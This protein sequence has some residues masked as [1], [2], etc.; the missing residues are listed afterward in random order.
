MAVA[1]RTLTTAPFSMCQGVWFQVVILCHP[2]RGHDAERISR[3]PRTR[4]IDWWLIGLL[5]ISLL[6]FIGAAIL[7]IISL[8]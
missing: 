8:L 6:S 1:I 4:R 7:G 5:L 2:C 3:V